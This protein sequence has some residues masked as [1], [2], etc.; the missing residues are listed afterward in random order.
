M[1]QESAQVA[2]QA[3]INHHQAGSLAEAEAL[4]RQVLAEFPRQ[5]D[6]LRFLGLLAHQRGQSGS[7]VDL[8]GAAIASAPGHA[9]AHADLADALLALGRVD[10]ALA[11]YRRALA[12][13]PDFVEAHNNLAL[14]L[15]E[16]DRP[17]E[18]LAALERAVALRPD[19]PEAHNNLGMLLE[20]QGR[21]GEA[22]ASLE[23]ALALRPGYPDALNNLGNALQAA[24]RLDDALHA[25]EA[26]LAAR[27]DHAAAHNNRGQVLET[28]GRGADALAAYRQATALRPD[29]A[30]AHWN[31][32]LALLRQGD[33]AA[34]W[35]LYEWRW[36]A[37]G[38]RRLVRDFTEPLWLGDSSLSGRTLL[39]HY[40]Q[41]L[42]DT[43]QMLRY[44]PVLAAQGAR[45]ILEVPPALAAVA[46]TVPG[47][48]TVVVEGSP[49][50]PFDLQCPLMSLPLACRTTLASIPDEVPYLFATAGAQ[51]AWRERLGPATGRRVGLA[52]SGSA[53][54]TSAMRARSLPL[55]ELLPA[56][57]GELEFHSLQ[58][59]YPDGDRERLAADGRIRDHAAL[60]RDFAA[61][62]GLVSQL[63]L[64]ITVD[65]AVAHLAG[66]LG[67]PVWLLLPF[68]ADYR[69]LQARDDSPW[70]PTMRLFR[71]PSPGDWG[72]VLERVMA[73]MTTLTP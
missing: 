2:L 65:T 29:F 14:A 19:F 41:G 71:Q 66:A 23:R 68:A 22:I 49:F 30:A 20:A 60:L 32:A 38:R 52:W 6:A 8:L 28:L 51:S 42:G 55:A 33:F 17:G 12:L 73:T 63:D 7:A 13:K 15:R 57:A 39:L 43:L 72:A 59:D 58:K 11:S 50:P 1:T 61:T 36:Q 46:A 47:G 3:A 27:P 5:P 26:L 10:E 70:Y 62:A 31:E 25:Y 40:E 9:P 35:R 45:L 4:Y 64:V 54:H 69:W 44:L 67:K 34:G 21:P 48:A 24:G 18:A 37:M 56:L 16:L 53:G